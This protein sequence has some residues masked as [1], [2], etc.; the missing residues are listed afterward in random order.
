MASEISSI[1]TPDNEIHPLK[2]FQARAAISAI[3]TVQGLLSGDGAGHFQRAFD[4]LPATA[5]VNGKALSANPTLSAS[6][7]GASRTFVKNPD[8]NEYKDGIQSDLSVIKLTEAEYADLLRLNGVRPNAIYVISSEYVNSYGMQVKNVAF[9]TDLS[10]AVNVEQL[11]NAIV[12]SAGNKIYIDDRISSTSGYSDLSIIRLSA[13]E[14]ENLPQEQRQL[15]NALYVVEDDTGDNHGK[16]IKNLAP[17]TDLSDAVNLEQLSDAISSIQIPTDLSSFTNSPGYLVSNDISDY[18]KKSE[19]SSASEIQ[20]AL[21]EKQPSG[22][23]A[24]TS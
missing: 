2:D 22:D 18:Y 24:L 23:Y 17:G 13:S 21:D 1:K 11:S 3:N 16:Q 4:M 5:T 14:Y 7:V 20:S 10:D 12:L 19:T 9:G 8:A 15:S 6:D